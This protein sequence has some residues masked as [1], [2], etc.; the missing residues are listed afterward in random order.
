MTIV[1]RQTDAIN[2]QKQ[3]LIHENQKLMANLTQVKETLEFKKIQFED[4]DLK[5]PVNQR[6]KQQTND[7]KELSFSKSGNLT[8]INKREISK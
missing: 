3:A 2:N 4:F 5:I 8:G 7:K 6:K 1:N